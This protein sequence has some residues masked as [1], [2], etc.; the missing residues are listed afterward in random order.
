MLAVSIGLLL[1]VVAQQHIVLAIAMFSVGV[2]G[3][4]GYLPGFWAL[5]TAF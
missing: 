2:V 4:Y 1:G 5:P 3:L